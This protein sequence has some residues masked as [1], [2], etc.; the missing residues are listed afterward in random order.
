MLPTGFEGS[1]P[2][3]YHLYPI[4][5]GE[6][7]TADA[8]AEKSQQPLDQFRVLSPLHQGAIVPIRKDGSPWT[9]ASVAV[10]M[11]PTPNALACYP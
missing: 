9:G 11:D 10:L 7:A 4:M 6:G 2:D 8:F 3:I 1:D 5:E